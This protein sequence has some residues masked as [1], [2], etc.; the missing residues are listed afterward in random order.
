MPAARRGGTTGRTPP[1]APPGRAAGARGRLRLAGQRG[2]VHRLAAILADEEVTQDGAARDA[3][4]VSG[5]DAVVALAHEDPRQ[6]TIGGRSRHLE[7]GRRHGDIADG[8]GRA[9]GGGGARRGRAAGA[10]GIP[11]GARGGGG[12]GGG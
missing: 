8:P 3:A 5:E 10:G 11:P 6:G 9:D 12:G 7:F 4:H 1:P 2:D